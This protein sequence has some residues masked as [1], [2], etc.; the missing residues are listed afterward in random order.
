MLLSEELHTT[1]SPIKQI[2]KMFALKLFR[3]FFKQSILSNLCIGF[4]KNDILFGAGWFIFFS[5]AIVVFKGEI[6]DNTSQE[7]DRVRPGRS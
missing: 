6:I 4:K 2:S 7:V 5:M 3:K 1:Q